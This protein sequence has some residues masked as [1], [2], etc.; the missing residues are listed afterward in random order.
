MKNL[1]LITV[2]LVAI[3]TNMVA[4][5]KSA[6]E[7]KGLENQPFKTLFTE[8]NLIKNENNQFEIFAKEEVEV[9]LNFNLK[10]DENVTVVINDLENNIVLSKNLN[11]AGINKITLTMNENEKY[12][13]K[14][15]SKNLTSHLVS[16]IEN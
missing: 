2:F 6:L 16:Y 7:V 4:Q 5:E 9:Y 14:L 13:V 8:S 12:T 1:L 15:I 10:T 11:K 3:T